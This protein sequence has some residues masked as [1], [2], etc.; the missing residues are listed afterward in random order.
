LTKPAALIRAEIDSMPSEL[1]EVTRRILQL[2]IER[3]AL[4]RE[5]DVASKLRLQKVE[6][7]LANLKED[8][9]ALRGRW[10]E[11]KEGIARLRRIKEEIEETR[12]AME[13]AEQEY[14]LNRLA[15]L[16]YGKMSGA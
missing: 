10:E 2:E 5:I 7:E 3:E 14:D 13:K 4:K 6:E 1:D 8:A 16:R 12:L 15:E 9:A 11:E